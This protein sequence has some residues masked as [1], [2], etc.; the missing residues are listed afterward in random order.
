MKKY[1]SQ[2]QTGRSLVEVMIALALGLVVLLAV[3]SMFIGNRGTYRSMDDKARMD[4][5]GR[6]ALQLLVQH[7]RM[8]GYGSISSVE[9]T[10]NFADQEVTSGTQTTSFSTPAIYTRFN[11][12]SGA[13]GLGTN[14]IRG[15]RTGFADAKQMA[16]ALACAAGGTSDALM[17]RYEVDA[18]SS[19]LSAANVPTDCVG[20]AIVASAANDGTAIFIIDNRFFIQNNPIT[21]IPELYCQGNGGTANYPNATLT[22]NPQPLAE[23]VE[24]MTITYGLLAPALD[25]EGVEIDPTRFFSQSINRYVRAD[26]VTN[27]NQVGTVKICLVMR[28]ANNSI[29][30]APQRYNNCNDTLITP[31]D[32]YLRG[33]YISTVAIR[34]RIV[35]V[36]S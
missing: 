15:C 8:A 34:N 9:K 10:K 1:I 18:N 6:L 24:Q 27:W 14:A 4:E 16:N 35:G 3:S 25:S 29:T 2:F 11:Q 22:S 26:Q 28:S 17:V 23:N 30:T 12:V 5:E 21:L 32:R 7:V 19:N 13:A 33:V 20:N 36:G 31:T